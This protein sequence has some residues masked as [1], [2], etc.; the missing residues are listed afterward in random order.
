MHQ[1]ETKKSYII[2][3]DIVAIYSNC[4]MSDIAK[5]IYDNKYSN[6]SLYQSGK[7]GT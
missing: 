5:Y 7:T 2:I 3:S 1:R 6:A 4:L